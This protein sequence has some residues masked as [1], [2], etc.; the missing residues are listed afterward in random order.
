MV[1]VSVMVGVF[2]AVLVGVTGVGVAVEVGVGVLV[3]N[4]PG[5]PAK[6]PVAHMTTSTSPATMSRPASTLMKVFPRFFFL[7]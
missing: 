1:G 2:V 6:L 7:R 4:Q 3:A 5:E